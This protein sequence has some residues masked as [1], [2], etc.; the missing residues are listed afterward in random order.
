MKIAVQFISN[1]KTVRGN[2]VQDLEDFDCQLTQVKKA[3]N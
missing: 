1:D 2:T 3:N